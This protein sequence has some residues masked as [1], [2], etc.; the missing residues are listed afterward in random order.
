M[1]QWTKKKKKRYLRSRGSIKYTNSL[2]HKG[3]KKI[4]FQEGIQYST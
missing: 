3:K 4:Y 2:N 1:L